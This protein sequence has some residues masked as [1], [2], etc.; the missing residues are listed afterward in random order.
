MDTLKLWEMIGLSNREAICAFDL[1]YRLSAFNQ[2]HN[3]EFFRVN[4]FYTK[5][6][7]VFPDLFPVSQ[8]KVMR[9][10]MSRALKGE[11]FSAVER[12]GKTEFGSPHWEIAYAPIRDANGKIVG[13]FHHARDLT[14]SAARAA[15]I[16]RMDDYRRYLDDTGLRRILDELDDRLR[17]VDDV[18]TIAE[19]CAEVVGK[20]LNA[21]ISAFG[22]VLSDSESVR[23]ERDWTSKEA[24]S[25]VGVHRL[26]DFGNYLGGLRRGDDV[27]ANDVESEKT[28]LF[29]TKA[30]RAIGA[31]AAVNVP[32]LERGRFV[33]VFFVLAAEPRPW[34][35]AELSFV[36]NVAQR[37]HAATERRRAEGELRRLNATL[38]RQVED[39]TRELVQ[40]EEA[41]RQSQKME[42]VGQLTGGL[43]HD[44]NNLLTGI[45]GS[46]EL[47][48][49]RVSQ[50]RLT[51]LDRYVG[52]AQGA[53]QR[54]AALTDRLL[55]FSRR[56][57][58]DPKSV[59]VN[60]LVAGMEDLVRH[61]VGPA[62][63]LETIASSGLWNTLI[64]PGQLESALLNLCIN[65]RDAT[66]DGGKLTI[67][68]A[69][70]WLDEAAARERDL[71]PG[72]FVSLTVSDTGSGMTS[73]VVA[74]AFE[75]FYTT[76]PIGTGTGLGLS[77]V[78]GFAR[79]SGGQVQI[80]SE[81]GT[82]TTISLYLPRDLGEAEHVHRPESIPAVNNTETG[83]TVL[84]VEDEPTVRQLVCEVLI[85]MGHTPLEAPDAARGLDILKSNARLDLLISDVGLPGGLNGRQLA[86]AARVLRPTLKVL[87]MTGYAESAVSRSGHLAPGMHLLTKPFDL[88]GLARRIKEVLRL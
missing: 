55:A 48:S 58:L 13:A 21:D 1:D 86:D 27:V 85:E 23:V 71:T 45:T 15:A 7:D 17:D 16:V 6:G 50:G 10:L 47:L 69:N 3:D 57:T 84:V 63:E 82:G 67:E 39:R 41:L 68:T 70:F 25:V 77:M 59:N 29:N 4:G 33:A 18:I 49:L 62:I 72:E 46:L 60:R 81:V 5:I 43:A 26:R 83:L 78:Y 64:D 44:F 87:F 61:T 38:G 74:R 66:H 80:D 65:A 8:R 51:D 53:A 88:A 56:Q 19:L 34:S 42:A 12:F 76:K 52:A 36:R 11:T 54:A 37:A 14:E 28:G 9:S 75:P 79:Q 32:L 30:F 2:A 40:T 20:T 24:S 73:D 22:T 31:R 35:A